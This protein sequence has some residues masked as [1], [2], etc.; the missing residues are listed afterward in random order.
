MNNEE[1]HNVNPEKAFLY[2]GNTFI[3]NNAVVRKMIGLMQKGLNKK[4]LWLELLM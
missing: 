1:A 4:L 2:C 3:S